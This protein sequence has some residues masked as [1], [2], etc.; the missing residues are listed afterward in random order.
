MNGEDIV[1]TL[2]A[3]PQIRPHTRPTMRV[4]LAFALSF[5]IVGGLSVGLLGTSDI[6]SVESGGHGHGFILN[7]VFVMSVAACA[8]AV[9]RDLSVPARVVSLTKPA[10]VAPFALMAMLVLHEFAGSSLHELSQDAS[11]VFWLS[12]LWQIIVLATP[13]FALLT[14]G[15]RCLAP[16]E[17]RRTGAY[18]GMLAGALGAM[19]HC[20][21]VP[22]EPFVLGALLYTAGIGTMMLAGLLL[23]PRLLR[24]A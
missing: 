18:I 12:C 24:W 22:T 2:S 15:M 7:F 5:A 9:V 13:A 20:W 4:V 23:G 14:F 1:D 8:L 17:L 6:H 21:H 19:G 16:T 11:Q 3:S 10:L